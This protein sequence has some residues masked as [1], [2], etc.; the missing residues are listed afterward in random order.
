MS[1][2]ATSLKNNVLDIDVLGTYEM[3]SV[4]ISNVGSSVLPVDVE[5]TA[6]WSFLIL[7]KPLK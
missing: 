5:Y 4:Q 7:F 6:Q 2:R 3:S 1:D